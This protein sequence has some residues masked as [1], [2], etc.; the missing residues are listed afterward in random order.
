MADR[1]TDIYG[2]AVVPPDG[3]GLE[4]EDFDGTEL[5]DNIVGL[6]DPE[7]LSVVGDDFS[8]DEDEEDD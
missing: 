1:T 6:D 2:N 3:S 7:W 5:L 4:D 8:Y